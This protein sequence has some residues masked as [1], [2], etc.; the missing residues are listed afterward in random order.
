VAGLAGRALPR[1]PVGR[2]M[3]KI[4]DMHGGRDYDPEWGKREENPPSSAAMT[5]S[6][7]ASPRGVSSSAARILRR[8]SGWVPQQPPMIRAPAIARQHRV[9]RHQLGR[10]V[11]MD[12]PVDV[13]RNARVALGDH[14]PFRSRRAEAQHGAQQVRGADAA[15]GPVGHGA[16]SSVSTSDGRSAEVKPIIV[17]PA[18]SKLI[19]PHQGMSASARPRRRR[20]IPR[21]PRSSR[22]RA[23]RRRRPSAPRPVRGTSPPPLV[24]QAPIGAMISPVGPM[25]PA[26]ITLR[27]AVGHLAPDLG[28]DR[29]SARTP[30]LRVVQLQPRRRAAEGVGQEQVRC[31]PRPRR[32][33]AW[34]SCRAVDVPQLGRVA[35]LQPHVEQRGSGGAIGEEPVPLVRPWARSRPGWRNPRPWWREP[36]AHRQAAAS[37]CPAR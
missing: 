10:P 29:G 13:F 17:R 21:A 33:R 16:G 20:G 5:S 28:G 8:C 18:V 34:R 15:I 7:G 9:T 23:H 4:R 22:P 12:M 31:R 1:P 2:V 32:D 6:A 36:S 19:V 24:G 35:R 37:S 3:T 25:E 14:R 11:V 30:D 27:P 26:T